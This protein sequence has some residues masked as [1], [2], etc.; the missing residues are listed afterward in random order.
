MDLLEVWSVA[1]KLLL[2]CQWDKSGMDMQCSSKVSY[3]IS[4]VRFLT[5]T[6]ALAIDTK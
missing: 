5:P 1:Q 4:T 3:I 2:L 6:A